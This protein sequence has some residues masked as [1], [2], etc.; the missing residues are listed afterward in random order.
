MLKVRIVVV[1]SMVAL[2]FPM[3]KVSRVPE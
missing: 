3:L 2:S 1:V